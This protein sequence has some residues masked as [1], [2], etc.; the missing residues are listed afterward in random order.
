M[1][2][3]TWRQLDLAKKPVIILNI[4][5]YWDHLLAMLQKVISEGFMHH[6]H[7]DHFE[8]VTDVSDVVP[9]L[10]SL[11]DEQATTGL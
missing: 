3:T 6:D 4:N 9:H 5:G 2:I 7:L 10:K 8:T 11:G 1:E